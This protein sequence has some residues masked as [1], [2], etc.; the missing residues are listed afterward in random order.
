MND[1][2]DLGTAGQG[3]VDGTQSASSLRLDTLTLLGQV[4]FRPVATGGGP[5]LGLKFGALDVHALRCIGS[6]FFEVIFLTGTFVTPRRIG[7]INYQLPVEF[8]SREVGLAFLAYAL[9]S[10]RIPESL[11]PNWLAEGRQYAHLLPWER[12]QAAYA[13]RPRCC[14]KRDWLRLALRTLAA[15]L[16]GASSALPVS[17]SFDGSQLTIR[18][19]Q[20]VVPMPAT[21]ER[22]AVSYE[23]T[24]G[25]M[26]SPPA[27]LMDQEVEVSVHEE[28]MTIGRRRYALNL[29]R[30]LE[31]LL[32]QTAT[33]E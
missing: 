32:Q 29:E 17:F 6:G 5:G 2:P 15:E 3:I 11:E 19:G 23:L 30:P 1:P 16:A 4:G 8:E 22:W 12:R 10:C 14:V 28:A 20:M 33:P 31:N 24:A 27:R 18:A 26:M 9:R 25:Q 7:L 13:R 21:G